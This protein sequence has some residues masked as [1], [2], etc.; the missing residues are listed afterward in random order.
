MNSS[1]FR[2]ALRYE[3]IKRRDRLV[4]H[5]SLRPTKKSNYVFVYVTKN[6]ENIFILTGHHS[7]IIK[8]VKMMSPLISS[9]YHP[10]LKHFQF[11]QLTI[12]FRYILVKF[13]LAGEDY[14]ISKLVTGVSDFNEKNL[15]FATNFH[16]CFLCFSSVFRCILCL[17]VICE[18]ELS[19]I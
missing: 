15:V 3:D 16:L 10:T 1:K 2:I 13:L 18:V 12:L 7:Y 6:Q 4:Y 14:S 11:L 8:L 5:I 9:N 17:K 19:K